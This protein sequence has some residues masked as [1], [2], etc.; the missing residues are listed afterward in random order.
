MGFNRHK[1]AIAAKQ[2]INRKNKLR[3]VFDEN[4]RKDFLTGFRRRKDER[5]KKAKEQIELNLKNEI[6]KI[7]SE[8]RTQ[9]R[10]CQRNSC[11]AQFRVGPSGVAEP[12]PKPFLVRSYPQPGPG[13]RPPA[14]T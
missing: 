9:V 1:S 14:P 5:R 11:G 10:W 6:K 12:E 8:S 7:K 3:I 4:A 2:Q 13:T